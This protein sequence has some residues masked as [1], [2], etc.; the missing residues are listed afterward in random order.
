MVKKITLQDVARHAGVSTGTIDRVIHNRGKVSA[1]KKAR[2][3][4]AIKELKFNPNLLAR[5]LALGHQYQVCVLVPSASSSSH[6]WS[7]PINGIEIASQQFKDYGIVTELFLYDLY[8][9]QTFVEQAN[10]ILSIAPDAVV[11]APLF[12]HESK[13]FV[14]KLQQIAIPYIFIDA[15]LPGG[16]GFSYIGPDIR[17][18]AFIA[19][20]LLNSILPERTEVV[21]INLV[22]G[23]E[24]AASIQQIEHGFKSY[25]ES[26]HLTEKK[27][28]HTLTINST[29]K[30]NIF[31]SLS[32][33]YSTH[34][35]VKGAF[36][37][38]SKAFIVS[39]FH[40][41]N[42]L[43][44]RLIGYDLVEENVQHVRDGGI[45]FIISQNP[46]QQGKR[47]IQT[48]FNYFVYKTE[49]EK[50]QHIPLDIIIKENL[51]FYLRFNQR[52]QNDFKQLH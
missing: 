45:D 22:K 51:E 48:F 1:E 30:E 32:K 27:K 13:L 8:K 50:V 42:K 14:Q 16:Q 9:E 26:N 23:F 44:I 31:N 40:K 4:K 5:T 25:Y 38:N 29:T 36:I 19:G 34:P 46:I 49:P 33:F 41:S 15:D 11:V 47:A 6:Y 18:S 7:M 43:D 35:E 2:V 20:K 12:Y 28:I 52:F 37:S 24:N 39:E 21:I 3:E 10:K 17:S